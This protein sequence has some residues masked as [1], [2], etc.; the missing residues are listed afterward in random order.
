MTEDQSKKWLAIMTNEYMSSEESDD[1]TM[2]VHSLPWRSDY[3][4]RMFKSIDD[5]CLKMKS[6]QAKRQMKP[7]VEGSVSNHSSPGDGAPTWAVRK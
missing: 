1:E 5:Y 2:L 7:R 4:N 6:P 3:V